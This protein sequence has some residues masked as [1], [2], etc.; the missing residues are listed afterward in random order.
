[1]NGMNETREGMESDE[2]S[3]E[4][5]DPAGAAATAAASEP[6]PEPE[7]APFDAQTNGDAN[8]GATIPPTIHHDH[9]EHVTTS[10]SWEQTQHAEHHETASDLHAADTD[11]HTDT[12]STDTHPATDTHDD[13]T[14]AHHDM[15]TDPPAT[16]ETTT[17]TPP[18]SNEHDGQ[19]PYQ[20]E[21]YQSP[22]EQYSQPPSD[23]QLP[24]P[25]SRNGSYPHT[26]DEWSGY[27]ASY[28]YDGNSY[29]S[30]DGED[31]GESSSASG[32][33]TES[34]R[35]TAQTADASEKQEQEQVETQQSDH[36][37]QHWNQSATSQGDF[38]STSGNDMD[39]TTAAR[40]E[41]RRSG[42]ATDAAASGTPRLSD[43]SLL[44]RAPL[45]S[46]SSFERLIDRL[47][48][49]VKQSSRSNTAADHQTA[50]STDADGGLNTK[51]K[52]KVR[53]SHSTSS[54]S[55]SPTRDRFPRSP[56][57]PKSFFSPTST[58]ISS[59]HMS[60]GWQR[61][62]HT[63][64]SGVKVQRRLPHL[65]PPKNS[66]HI[67]AINSEPDALTTGSPIR[68]SSRY[69][70]AAKGNDNS[71]IGPDAMHGG[72]SNKALLKA[73]ALIAAPSTTPLYEPHINGT[74]ATSP[75]KRGKFASSSVR[76]STAMPLSPASPSS[77]L[78]HPS[79]SSSSYTSR[80]PTR[81]H[82]YV[83]LVRDPSFY[84]R[85]DPSIRFEDILALR[86]ELSETRKQ[87]STL[88]QAL[89][90]SRAETAR[91]QAALRRSEMQA[92]APKVTSPAWKREQNER[93]LLQ[94]MLLKMKRQEEELSHASME[95]AASLR[96]T[97][98]LRTEL[99]QARTQA[100]H[101]EAE[102]RHLSDLLTK[103]KMKRELARFLI[104][105]GESNDMND[106]AVEVERTLV[107][108]HQR[109][110][111]ELLATNN[112]LRAALSQRDAAAR[113]WRD[114][115]LTMVRHLHDARTLIQET[116]RAN[117][118]L[119]SQL[120]EAHA[121]LASAAAENEIN[122]ARL[123]KITHA[124]KQLKHVYK[125]EMRG[126]TSSLLSLS[127]EDEF[128]LIATNTRPASKPA[129][130]TAHASRSAPSPTRSTKR[131]TTTDKAQ[132][133]KTQTNKLSSQKPTSTAQHS[134]QRVSSSKKS[135][136]PRTTSPQP[137]STSPT[138]SRPSRRSTH[139]S[140]GTSNP[141]SSPSASASASA[142]ASHSTAS[143]NP[144]STPSDSAVPN[145]TKDE[146]KA[147]N[148]SQIIDEETYEED[149]Y[150]DDKPEE[151][152]EAIEPHTDVKTN[153]DDHAKK[154]NQ[155]SS[156]STDM[157]EF[158][159]SPWLQSIA[160]SST[161][162]SDSAAQSTSSHAASSPPLCHSCESMVASVHCTSCKPPC[163]LCHE[164]DEE[165]HV[166]GAS[167]Q[168][169]RVPLSGQAHESNQAKPKA[170]TDSDNRS[171]DIGHPIPS[172]PPLFIPPHCE[173]CEDSA[174]VIYC[175]SCLSGFQYLCSACDDS[176]HASKK[177]AQHDRQKLQHG[178]QTDVD[179]NRIHAMVE[180]ENKPDTQRSNPTSQQTQ[181]DAAEDDSL[182]ASDPTE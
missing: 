40:I 176:C 170:E 135:G 156:T 6:E 105:E 85:P 180:S 49:D 78:T 61:G 19:Y 51:E 107:A 3:H 115:E 106:A 155:Q 69:G 127:D 125:K 71:S 94:A 82:S 173:V 93:T 138:R 91:V 25:D 169:Q 143:S 92:A 152:K 26:V 123:A 104:D 97:A 121:A 43:P 1:M 88:Q 47:D 147:E 79:S 134:N 145:Q 74:A 80:S 168:H 77:P 37:V 62:G 129:V 29:P 83:S 96:Q 11:T 132:S 119:R 27:D 114:E 161:S 23:G 131:A 162:A 12:E 72:A 133:T 149:E 101:Y 109:E 59:S 128:D 142:S 130:P 24:Q 17:E 48:E 73:A 22:S 45:L 30:V 7:P 164:C 13:V 144:D 181:N 87:Q 35:W 66:R 153:D 68:P 159:P 178:K 90:H 41:S 118:R 67:F 38:N 63:P 86:Q 177:M 150:E 64:R 103:A 60:K 165:L 113:R 20:S 117:D 112:E 75:I 54:S 21:S 15:T 158:S 16:N 100:N 171:N 179:A 46:S 172:E 146:S 14:S 65:S 5:A 58:S 4:M 182:T 110:N 151:R 42:N 55:L 154:S 31:K 167:K 122:Q 163:S 32:S 33:M 116:S 81:A 137:S 36:S 124:Y 39:G 10:P 57:T 9:D 34:T 28:T 160:A 53:D 111:K 108:F 166:A 2:P 99:E 98:D 126:S 141:A 56:D 70:N 76:P 8:A 120:A 89:T 174:P 139:S 140:V 44:D 18:V 52:T 50:T 175:R 148:T 136:A 157:K 102:A 84:S 95:R